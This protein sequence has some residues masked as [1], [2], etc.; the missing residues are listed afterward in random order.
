MTIAR[1]IPDLFADKWE[2]RLQLQEEI[3]QLNEEIDLI[4]D[5]EAGIDE[6]IANLTEDLNDQIE[7]LIYNKI[8]EVRDHIDDVFDMFDVDNSNLNTLMVAAD[9][10]ELFCNYKEV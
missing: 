8:K 2:R 5:I 7:D 1:T 3:D 6:Q 4:T 9:K 10:V